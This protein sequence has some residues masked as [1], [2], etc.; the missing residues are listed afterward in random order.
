MNPL[1]VCTPGLEL[2][3][4]FVLGHFCTPALAH[5]CTPVWAPALVSSYTPA[6]AHF[7]TPALGS[8][9]KYEYK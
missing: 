2:S 9:E 3:H 7:C 1:P 6:W 4:T 5:S 8:A